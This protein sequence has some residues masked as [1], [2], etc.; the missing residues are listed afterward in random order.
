MTGNLGGLAP[1]NGD[2]AH[3]RHAGAV[4]ADLYEGLSKH[5]RA[6]MQVSPG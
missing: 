2:A 1:A 5:E 4:S 6:M 3:G